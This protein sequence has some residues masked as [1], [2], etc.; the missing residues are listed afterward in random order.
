MTVD[1]SVESSAVGNTE[2]TSEEIQQLQ[3]NMRYIL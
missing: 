1:E 3:Q 2:L